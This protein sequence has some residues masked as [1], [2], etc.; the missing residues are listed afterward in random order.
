[1]IGLLDTL[2]NLRSY[3]INQNRLDQEN[4]SHYLKQ[5][6]FN[7]GVNLMHTPKNSFEFNMKN[8]AT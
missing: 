5:S 7:F 3:G 1:M 8:K 2:L 4:E 6:H